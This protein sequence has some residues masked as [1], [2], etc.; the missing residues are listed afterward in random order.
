MKKK[1]VLV[2]IGTFQNYLKLNRG[3]IFM[4]LSTWNYKKVKN[5]SIIKGMV[6]SVNNE[7]F[8]L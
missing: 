8:I 1:R 5:V 2:S 4:H 7:L 6:S 3:L